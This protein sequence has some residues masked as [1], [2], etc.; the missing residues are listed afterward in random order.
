[1]T[2]HIGQGFLRYAE[3]LGFNHRIQALLQ[4]V[5]VELNF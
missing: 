3:T 4:R 5:G 2:H 1:V